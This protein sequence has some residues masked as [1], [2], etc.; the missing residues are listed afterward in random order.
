[1][2]WLSTAIS[3]VVDFI[4][5]TVSRIGPVLCEF[6]KDVFKVFSKI[7]IEGVKLEHVIS[8]A[9]SIIHG[10]LEILGISLKDE[11]EILGAK[12]EQCDK[13]LDDFDDVKS[14]I[15][16]LQNEVE[17]DKERFDRLTFEEKLGCK[18]VG[19]TLEVYLQSV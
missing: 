2:G 8:I 13:N 1:M 19:M 4:S 15:H 17:L 14:Y 3:G 6:A 16:F 12:A 10:V 18:M 9:S 11:P 5:E 7:P